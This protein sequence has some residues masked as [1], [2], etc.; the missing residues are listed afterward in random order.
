MAKVQAYLHEKPAISANYL[1]SESS[2]YPL[3]NENT[4][5]YCIGRINTFEHLFYFLQ[6]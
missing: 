6:A 2:F 5:N 4:N 1:P 3:I